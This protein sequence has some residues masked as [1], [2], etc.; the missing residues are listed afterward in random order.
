MSKDLNKYICVRKSGD[1]LLDDFELA[2]EEGV[3]VLVDLVVVHAQDF[4]VDAGHGL[5][6]ALV[7]GGELELPEQAGADASRGGSGEADLYKR[8]KNL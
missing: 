1:E 5:D 4:E 8:K 3:L 6:Q 7:G 2:T